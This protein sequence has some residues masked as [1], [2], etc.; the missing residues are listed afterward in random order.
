MSVFPK[1]TVRVSKTLWSRGL[2][3]LCILSP[4]NRDVQLPPFVPTLCTPGIFGC[5]PSLRQ[6]GQGGTPLPL[7]GATIAIT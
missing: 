3:L 4:L 6:Q 7:L 2:R 1:H 5:F